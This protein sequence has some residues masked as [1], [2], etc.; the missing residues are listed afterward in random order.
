S[1]PL[2]SPTLFRSCHALLAQTPEEVRQSL[3]PRLAAMQPEALGEHRLT[4]E[5]CD[6]RQSEMRE[7]LQKKLDAAEKRVQ[8]VRE[9]IIGAMQAY[10][11][12][13]PLETREVDVAIEAADEYRRMLRV[14]I[15][16]DLPRFEGRFKELLKENAINEIAAFQAMLNGQREQINQRIEHINR[17]L[18]DIDYN[19]GRYIT[20][21]AEPAVDV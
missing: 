2:P 17:S 4:V 6:N 7:W 12:D 18:A 19:P 3:F 8:R 10:C 14:L 21:L 1:T 9:K 13:W 11:K 5:S 20:L 15:D 16:D